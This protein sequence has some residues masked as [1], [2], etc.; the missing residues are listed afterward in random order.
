MRGGAW[1]A[2]EGAS[3]RAPSSR[4]ES[5]ASSNTRTPPLTHRTPSTTATTTATTTTTQPRAPATMLLFCPQ[6]SNTLTVSRSSNPEHGGHNRLECRTC[7]YEFALT[8][9]Y[10]ER[11]P[12]KRKEVDDVM[13]GEGAWDNVD[14]T[15]TQCAVDACDGA[16][17]YFYMVQI[18]S[19]DEPMT[20][21]YK[22]SRTRG[23]PAKAT[24]IESS[25]SLVATSGGRDR[26]ATRRAEKKKTCLRDREFAFWM[27]AH[28]SFRETRNR[29]GIINRAEF[30]L[31]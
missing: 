19:A 13:G 6:C 28:I 1:T 21:F 3:E 2:P 12:M 26:A 31:S 27:G 4:R 29:A 30:V 25:A 11:R 9:K 14:Q 7:P 24:L 10:Y 16:R 5:F 23:P 18:R 17:A 15:D 20:T 22:V 8:R